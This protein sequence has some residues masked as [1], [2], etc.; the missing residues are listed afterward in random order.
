LTA[1]SLPPH[2][3][4]YVACIVAAGAAALFHASFALLTTPFPPAWLLLA[5]L[6]LF[7]G[8]FTIKIPSIPARLSVTET[9]IFTCLLLFGAA[10]TTLTMA[11]DGLIVS[12]Y[13][14]HRLQQTLF[15]TAEAAL[16]I[17][18]ASHIF[19]LLA[20]PGVAPLAH[21]PVAIGRLILPMLVL[22][23]IYFLLNSGLTTIAVAFET[24]RSAVQ[25]WRKQFLWLS[26]NHFAGASVSLLLVGTIHQASVSV[27]AVVLPCLVI[28][29]LTF[30]ASMGR[31][32]DAESHLRQ[33]NRLYLSTVETLS[34]AIDAK[35]QVT[36]DHLRRVQA[37]ALGL[38][39]TLGVKDEAT[40]KALETAA[41]LH[42]VGKLA[43]PE[44]IL[45]KPGQLTPTEFEKM[46][47]H[48]GVGADILALIEFPHPV[49]PIVRHHHENWDGT[50][51]P[52]GLRGDAIPIG[53]RIL[54]VVDC[55]DA[56]SSDRPYRPRQTDEAALYILRQRRG[57]MYD[58]AVVDTFIN[59]QA[60]IQVQAEI[61]S[62]NPLEMPHQHALA[63]ISQASAVRPELPDVGR[64]MRGVEATEDMLALCALARSASGKATSVDAAFLIGMHLKRVLP[65][66]LCAVYVFD[67]VADELVARSVAGAGGA[68]LAGLR[69]PRGHRLTGWVAANQ[70]TML[71][72]DAVLDLEEFAL[73]MDPPLRTCLGTPLMAGTRLVGVLT[74]YSSAPAGFT[75]DH[76]RVVQMIAPHIAQLLLAALELESRAATRRAA[77][78]AG[79]DRRSSHSELHWLH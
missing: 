60:A 51:Y 75:E 15:N 24:G 35:D 45:N 67:P 77:V 53:A 19:L 4:L 49:V 34:A 20:V 72:S 62:E 13:R 41:L 31:V 71:N 69:I 30:R 58:P 36:H 3:Q 52:D 8:S 48:A 11:L 40:M 1:A 17:W 38:A 28:S 29:Y 37:Y 68:A 70:Q 10:P 32:A 54:A 47:R 74:A 26:I 65:C 57:T 64:A 12:L 56:L 73:K 18:I 61:A 43:V 27:V 7:S 44:Y 50:G 14:R 42:D 21:Q 25:L 79:R 5:A 46:K 63:H 6:T 55:F 2:G 33:L 16:S 9:L 78:D 66:A 22:T 39:R 23:S 76:S 59:V